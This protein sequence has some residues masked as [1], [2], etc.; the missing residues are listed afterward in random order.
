MV[1]KGDAGPQQHMRVVVRAIATHSFCEKNSMLSITENKSRMDVVFL[2]T[3][4]G[5]CTNVS[6]C[7]SE[8]THRPCENRTK[9]LS[10]PVV[11][12]TVK[13]KRYAYLGAP[14][15]MLIFN[16]VSM[17]PPRSFPT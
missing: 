12:G 17:H 9:I 8:V 5:D 1:W 11:G 3:H 2:H 13:P 6:N 15:H 10:I 14:H 16:A 7:V 4:L